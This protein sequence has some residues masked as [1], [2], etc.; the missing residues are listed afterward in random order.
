[1]ST[2]NVLCCLVI[3]RFIVFPWMYPASIPVS[4]GFLCPFCSSDRHFID[5]ISVFS[6]FL[7]TR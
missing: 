7:M 1:M 6:Y 2:S 4:G 5:F 3:I